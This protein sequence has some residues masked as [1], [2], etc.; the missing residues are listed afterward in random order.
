MDLRAY[1]GESEVWI[2]FVLRSDGGVTGDGFYLDDLAVESF[3]NGNPVANEG[4]DVQPGQAVLFENYPNPFVERT[5]IPFELPEASDVSLAVYDLLGHR[6]RVLADGV[7]T[8]G[9]HSVAWDGRDGA[10]QEVASG[11]YVVTLRAAGAVMTRK[12]LVV[13]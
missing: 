2:Q 1:E 7:H 5:L 3:T 8:A 11:V 13:R 4:D 6:V 10:G 12:L 9:S